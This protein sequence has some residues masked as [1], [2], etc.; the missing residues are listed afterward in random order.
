M[1]RLTW[2][3]TLHRFTGGTAQGRTAAGWRPARGLAAVAV[4]A[5]AVVGPAVLAPPAAAAVEA[6]L[7][8][9][10]DNGATWT[11][12]PT[13]PSGSSVLVRVWYN[14]TDPT[15]HDSVHATTTLPAGFT[16]VPGSTTVCLNPSTTAPLTPS[17]SELVC[18][19]SAGQSGAINEGAA[20]AGGVLRISPTAGLFGQPVGDTTG[21]MEIGKKRWL[22]LVTCQYERFGTRHTAHTG[23]GT[24]INAGTNTSN[25]AGDGV[26]CAPGGEQGITPVGTPSN[27]PL[28]LLGRR[29]LNL[30]A[31]QYVKDP[32][33]SQDLFNNY[34]SHFAGAAFAAGTNT[35]NSSGAGATCGPGD[36]TFAATLAPA[37]RPLDLLDNRYI[38]IVNYAFVRAPGGAGEDYTRSHGPDP[39]GAAFETGTNTSDT[40]GSGNTHGPGVAPYLYFSSSAAGVRALDTLDT[41]RGRGYV[42]FAMTAPTVQQSTSLTQDAEVAGANAT[43]ATVTVLPAPFQVPMAH[44]GLAAGLLG[45]TGIAWFWRRRT[46]TK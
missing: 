44:T 7:A 19:T 5:G 31:C 24:N 30:V 38:N 37:V 16:L 13:V 20:W 42:Q 33:A 18:N 36:S 17:D 46:A 27:L 25:T 14:N 11:A 2:R 15:P 32:G 34:G 9:S 26:T 43:P 39:R 8:Y 41:T 22:N 21:T 1:M 23:T 4:A 45:L 10:V 12:A 28:D 35:S 3:R 40:A 6:S 29:Y